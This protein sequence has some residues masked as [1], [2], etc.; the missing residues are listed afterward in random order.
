MKISIL[1][2][3][4]N[5]ELYLADCLESILA[6]TEKDWELFAID[7]FST[8][9]SWGVLEKYAERDARVKVF[10]NREK[11]I[12]HAL[13]LAFAKST[14]QL[15]TRMDS[16]DLMLPQKLERLKSGLLENGPGHLAVG[17]VEYFAEGGVG[18]G[19]LRYA[20]WLN[21]LTAEGKNFHHIYKECAVPSPAWMAWRS[22]LEKAGA[23]RSDIYPED[24][25]LAFR[26][27]QIGLEIIP[28]HEAIHRWRDRPDR[29]SRTD[30][31]YRDFTFIHLK[32]TWFLKTDHDPKRPLV[33][34]GAGKKGK[35]IARY[36]NENG[37]SF[38]WVTNNPEKIGKEIRGVELREVGILRQLNNPQVIVA[39]ASPNDQLEIRAFF[40][41]NDLE[42]GGHFF[43]FC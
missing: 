41:E 30:P 1:L 38:G 21:G 16:D 27:R 24:Y 11:G 14:G 3:V 12:V 17:Q 31:N 34:W 2:P 8:D 18:E 35:R 25:D 40:G 9:G 20:G 10:K 13:R 7:D 39:V 29:A 15:V 22:D 26:L 33:L 5:T 4:F 6:Q 28:G 19:Y 36:L 23:F 43:F 42:E 32:T 37:T